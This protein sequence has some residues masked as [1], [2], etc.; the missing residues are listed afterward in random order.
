MTNGRGSR[1]SIVL[2]LMMAAMLAACSSGSS[3]GSAASPTADPTKDKLA[4]VQARGTLVLYTD[5]AYPPQSMKI[6]GATRAPNTKCA[7]NQLTG[8]EMDGYDVATGKLVAAKLGV[9]PCFVVVPFD[10]VIA[11]GWGDRFDVAWGSGAMTTSRMEKL[12]VTQPYYT[13][14]ANFFVK[15]SSTYKT[16]AD[17]AGKQIGACSG[18]THEQYL[19]KTLS[20]PG[21]TLTY[22]VPDPKIVTFASEPP[23]LD[24]VAAGK[25]DAFLCSQPVG[26]EAITKGGDLRMLDTPAFYTYKTGYIDRSMTLAPQAFL[27]AIDGAIR[28]LEASGDLK[29]ASEKFFG[30]DYVTAA[31][32]FDMAKVNQTVP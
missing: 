22:A 9:E 12:Y 5:P 23:G 16:P 20:L 28:D 11:G 8:P 13:T 24:A 18:C 21:E 26:A 10:E 25:I 6:D 7:P 3:G 14:P 19:R 17:L 27:A 31:A 2:G 1:R 32:A 15:K 30:I 4:Q 29:A